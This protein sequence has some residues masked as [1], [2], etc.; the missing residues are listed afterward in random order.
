VRIEILFFFSS[1]VLFCLVESKSSGRY[2]T[3][4]K[5]LKDQIAEL[6]EKLRLADSEQQNIEEEK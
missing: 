3:Q 6:T 2:R 5:E 1:K 4:I